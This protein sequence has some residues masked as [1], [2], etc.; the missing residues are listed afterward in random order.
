MPAG[1]DQ[2]RVLLMANIPQPATML[3]TAPHNAGYATG[4]HRHNSGHDGRCGNY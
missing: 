4:G 1:N 2:G 3:G